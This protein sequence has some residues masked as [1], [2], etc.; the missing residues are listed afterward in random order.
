LLDELFDLTR[1]RSGKLEL[2]LARVRL[3]P[4]LLDIVQ[5]LQG[6]ADAKESFISLD[7]P[8]DADIFINADSL[9]IAQV[10]TNLVSNAIKY[11]NGTPTK[12]V[13]EEKENEVQISVSDQGKGI[14]PVHLERIFER[15]ER[16][17][18][19]P[20]VTGLGLG[21]YISKHIVDAHEGR[22]EVESEPGKGAKFTVHLPKPV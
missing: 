2:H 22:I 16:A 9:R 10:I 20:N 14:D 11:G 8:K 21:L 4:I 3:T 13:Y 17:N 15:F 7:G 6:E 18:D 19:D 1:M 5:T 12:I